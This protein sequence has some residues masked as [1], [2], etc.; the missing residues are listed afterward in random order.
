VPATYIEMANCTHD[1]VTDGE[2]ISG[3]RRCSSEAR[4]DRIVM[5]RAA[6][7]AMIRGECKP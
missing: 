1:N 5:H 2:V 4:D 7:R 6:A 3:G